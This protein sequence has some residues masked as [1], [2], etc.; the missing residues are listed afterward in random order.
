MVTHASFEDT[1]NIC[2]YKPLPKLKQLYDALGLPASPV[3]PR[4]D[5]VGLSD[6][7]N[8]SPSPLNPAGKTISRKARQGPAT[9]SIQTEYQPQQKI[10]IINSVLTMHAASGIILCNKSFFLILKT[11]RS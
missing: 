10:Y 11:Y 9:K 5:P 6:F 7:S 4:L 2:H 1:K 8:S 3:G